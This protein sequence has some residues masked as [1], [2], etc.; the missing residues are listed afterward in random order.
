MD[1]GHLISVSSI[2]GDCPHSFGVMICR[3]IKNHVSLIE[4]DGSGFPC[5]SCSG[6]PEAGALL[7]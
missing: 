5:S 3:K 4:D 1:A 2:Q 7:S 6:V